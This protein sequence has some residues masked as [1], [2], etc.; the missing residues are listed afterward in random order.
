M[1]AG[2]YSPTAAN[3][4]SP[5]PFPTIT[6]SQNYKIAEKIS[7][8]NQEEKMNKQGF[9]ISFVIPFVA[10][11]YV[12]SPFPSFSIC[13]PLHLLYYH[14][15]SKLQSIRSSI[16]NIFLGYGLICI[17]MDFSVFS[18]LRSYRNIR[19]LFPVFYHTLRPPFTL[20]T[21][22]ASFASH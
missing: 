2:R 15:F 7:C 9:M 20:Y 13:F 21:A 22:F 8:Q 1:L 4:A 19:P 11:F 14:I 17:S 18:T 6:E 3:A 12:Q 5:I 10:V 16:P